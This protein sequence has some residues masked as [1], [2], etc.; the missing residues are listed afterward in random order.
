MFN[1]NRPGADVNGI[2]WQK[3]RSQSGRV[4]VRRRQQKSKYQ[5]RSRVRNLRVNNSKATTRNRNLRRRR[6]WRSLPS[7]KDPRGA[8]L[9][10]RDKLKNRRRRVNRKYR[11]RG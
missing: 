10:Y 7:K 4:D 1:P 6:G 2:R 11:K 8:A 5:S 3:R 9:Q